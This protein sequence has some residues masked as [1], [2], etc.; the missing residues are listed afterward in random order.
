[1]AEATRTRRQ[2]LKALGLGAASLA[3]SGRLPADEP[4]GGRPN[5]IV[6]FT[7][8]QGYNDVGC[9]GSPKIRTPNFDRM[10]AEG[11]KFTSFYAQAVCGPS[12]AAL[13]TGCYPI[14]LAEPRS[15]KNQH[16]ILH[17]KEVTLAEVLKSAGYAAAC[18]GKWHLAGGGAGGRGRGPFPDELM[19][20]ARGFDSFYGTPL[21]NGFTREPDDRRFITQ[22]MR[23]RKVLESPTDMDLLTRRYT[24]EAVAFLRRNKARPFFLYLAHN[25]P[26]VPL[27]ASKD[28]RGRS[29]RGLYGDVIEELDWSAGRIIETLKELNIDERTLVVFTSDNGPWIEK[30]L[31]D[32]GGSADPLRGAKMMTWEGGLRTPCIMRWPGRIPAGRVCDRIATT[33][34]LL[35]TFARLAGAKLPAGRRLDGKDILPLMTARGGARSP[36]K[37]FYYYCYTHL[38]AVRTDRWKLVLPRP[39]RPPWTGWSARMVDAVDKAELYDLAADVGERRDLAAEH[40]DVVAELMKLVEAARADLGDHDRIG[41]GARFF[42]EPA[43]ATADERDG[44]RRARRA[45]KIVYKHPEPVGRLRFDFESGDLGGWRVVEGSFEAPVNDR[46]RFHHLGGGAKYNKQGKWFLTTLERAAGGKG[47]DAQ[48]GVIE[49]P[50]F[51]L[52]GAKM[53]FLVAG[54]GHADTYVALCDAE[55]GKELMTARG[56]GGE[57]MRRVNWDVGRYR[58]RKLLLRVVDRNT[59]G[60]GHVTFDDFSTEGE[61]DAAATARRRGGR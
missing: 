56:A 60:W 20:T 37:A 50:V 39:A 42:D 35:P 57:A 48:T 7:D 43:P 40:P 12:R 49:S 41:K 51:R 32:Y 28:F 6:F 15:R 5:F 19:P 54:G 55:G 52:T 14:R 47:K 9:F 44:R 11:M 33:M 4:A 2:F 53:S 16:T 45:T 25:M 61:L 30:H 24:D 21:H 31:G 1:M 29:K 3:A 8:D 17:P 26:H 13:M 18:I 36:H 59:G 22:L 10:A 38:Q 27:G 23:G 58:G 34:D 46:E